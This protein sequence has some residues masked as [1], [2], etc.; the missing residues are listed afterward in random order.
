MVKRSPSL[1]DTEATERVALEQV[2]RFERHV[3][4]WAAR[5]VRVSADEVDDAIVDTQR[6][7]VEVLD[8]DRCVLWQLTEGNADLVLTHV[9][10]RSGSPQAPATFAARELFPWLFSK[11]VAGQAVWNDSLDEIP[12]ETDRVNLRRFGTLSNAVVPVMLEGRVCGA[13]SFAAV[14]RERTWDLRWR[15]RL[16][17][18]AAV[19]GQ[20]LARRKNL[21]DLRSALT[22]IRELRDQLALEN[23]QLRREVKSLR[24]AITPIAES[25]RARSAMAETK[26]VASTDATV[27]FLGETGVGKEVFAQTLH[28]LSPRRARPMVCV[29]CA[30]IPATLIESELFGREK[31][32]YTGALSRQAGRFELADG[33]TI[34]LDEIAELPLE[35]QGKL[36]RVLEN[37]TVER[38]SLTLAF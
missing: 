22:E 4:E 19:F 3:T 26:L 31:G 13:L 16:Q 17:L 36:L 1:G 6:Q 30:A 25:A 37:R 8:I 27:L 23:V 14:R 5:F 9:H 10:V 15:E 2:L 38:L 20:A 11:V 18:L 34:V 7:I 21:L 35:V 32:A 12:S 29:N 28:D 24:H 33:S